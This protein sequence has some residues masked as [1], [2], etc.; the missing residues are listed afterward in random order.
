MMVE[1]AGAT[2]QGVVD[3]QRPLTAP[4]L[5]FDLPVA[6]AP[7]PP[8]V[9]EVK[10][11]GVTRMAEGARYEFAYTWNVRNRN[12]KVPEKLAVDVVGARDIRITDMK[13]SSP[14]DSEGPITGTFLVH[15]SKATDP[16]RY[17]MIVGT[18]PRP[19]AAP[20]EEIVARPLALEVMERRQVADVAA[21]K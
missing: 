2:A 15:T 7:A 18:P 12:F 16:G 5:G 14:V 13:Q 17:D 8:A 11:T 4:W 10:Q 6:M 9:L 20:G 3:R 19:G 1:V 21:V